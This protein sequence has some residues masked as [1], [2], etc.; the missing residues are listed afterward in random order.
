MK[1]VIAAL[2]AGSV[3]AFAPTRVGKATSSLNAFKSKLGV[4]A[5]LGFFDPIGMLEGVDQERFDRLRYVEVK[6][7]RICQLAFL[8]QI[9]TR[10]GT[11]LPGD[12]NFLAIPLTPSPMAL[13]PS[14]AP[15]PFPYLVLARSLASS[16]FLS[17][18]L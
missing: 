12:I 16:D 7:G 18:L 2:L 15:M 10:G 13:L 3:A 11:H 14:L 5:P 8:G 9:F 17:S 6:H 1:L 4:Q